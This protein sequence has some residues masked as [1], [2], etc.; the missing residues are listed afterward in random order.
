MGKRSSRAG[1]GDTTV[2]QESFH[3]GEQTQALRQ[4]SRW[5]N[6]RM[7]IN[8]VSVT[9]EG[10]RTNRLTTQPTLQVLGVHHLDEM[11]GV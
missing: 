4:N 2:G 10:C 6:A 5:A 1:C 9:V 8:D 11:D 3:R 7:M